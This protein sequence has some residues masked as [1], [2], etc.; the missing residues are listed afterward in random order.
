M[1]VGGGDLPEAQAMKRAFDFIVALSALTL[2]APLFIIIC[3]I[4]LF[5]VGWPIFY[6]QIRVGKGAVPFKIVKLRSM[7][8]TAD[9]KGPTLTIDGDPR[10]TAVGR[11]L[12]RTK[13]DELPQLL[14]VLWGDMSLVGPRP[15]V[16]EYVRLYN[17]RQLKVLSVRPGLTDPASIVYRDEEKVLAQYDDAEKIYTEKI[18][19]AKLKLNLSYIEKATF[20]TDLGII[21][22]TLQKLFQRR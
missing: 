11:L 21:I 7:V 15:E 17:E 2:L 20:L 14:N 18:M 10:I 19:P 6:R 9:R 13:L 3:V 4:I 8:R 1:S 12:R 5:T 22:K 16:A